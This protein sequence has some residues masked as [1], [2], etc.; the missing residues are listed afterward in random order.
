MPSQR[1]RQEEEVVRRPYTEEGRLMKTCSENEARRL[2]KM[3]IMV[4]GG[5]MKTEGRK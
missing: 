4:G 1:L 5:E 3:K 2:E